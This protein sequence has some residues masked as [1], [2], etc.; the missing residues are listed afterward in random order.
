MAL[1]IERL[2][3]RVGAGTGD[4]ALLQEALDDATDVVT[5]Y[6]EDCGKTV[7]TGGVS[8]RLFERA[9]LRC[10]TT[11]FNQDKAPSGVVNQQYDIGNGEIA[12]TP[13][14]IG[15]DPMKSARAL[16]AAAGIAPVGAA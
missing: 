6:I 3:K 4:N 5:T 1:N 14:Q 12:S 2:R 9:V 13:A 10:A 15:L 7:G 11:L 16:L 8:V